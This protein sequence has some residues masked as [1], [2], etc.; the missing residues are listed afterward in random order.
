MPLVGEA[1]PHDRRRRHVLGHR[2]HPLTAHLAE[3]AGRLR[4]RDHRDRGQHHDDHEQ[5][6]H[7]EL[8][9]QAA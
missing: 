8:A 3:L 2:D 7:Q 5:L 9:G 6:K 4:D 1:V